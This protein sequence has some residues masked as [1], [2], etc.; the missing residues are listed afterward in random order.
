MIACA[1][2]SGVLGIIVGIGE[3]DFRLIS[4]LFSVVL[5]SLPLAVCSL[6]YISIRVFGG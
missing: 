1:V 4:D 5:G 6:F 3:A 2:F